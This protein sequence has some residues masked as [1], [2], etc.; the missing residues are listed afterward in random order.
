MNIL[1]NNE[2]EILT[3]SGW[4]PFFGLKKGTSPVKCVVNF[5]D[6]NYIE[7]TPTHKIKTL[8]GE[9]KNAIDLVEG[10]ILSDEKI[11]NNVDF[12]YE[13]FEYV[14]VI[15]VNGEEYISGNLIHHNCAHVKGA[16]EIWTA[17]QATLSTGGKAMLLST[18]NG[19]G[20]FFHKTWVGSQE[21]TNMFHPIKIEWYHHP[22]RDEAWKTEQMKVLQDENRFKQEHCADFISSGNTVIPGFII[23]KY[24]NNHVKEPMLKRGF[25]KNLWVWKEVDYSKQYMVVADCARGDGE[26]YSGCHVIELEGCEQVAEY[27]GKLDTTMYG[28]LLVEIAT[29]YNDALLIVENATSGWA[30][31]QKIIDRNY[32]NLFYMTD[33]VKVVEEGSNYVSK[34]YA[35]DKKKVAGFTTSARTRPLIISKLQ[36]YMKEESIIIHSSRTISELQVFIWHNGKA[37]AMEGYNDD[38]VMSLS[39]GLWVR[40]TA[41]IIQDQNSQLA[42]LALN[43]IHRTSENNYDAVILHPKNLQQDPYKIPGMGE[44]GDFRWLI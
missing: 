11:V 39:I 1:E 6:G 35:Q 26:D 5:Y 12:I 27:K 43:N 29:S 38:L 37:Q 22:D 7:S 3:P 16:E 14:S 10:D 9:F 8:N 18:P 30:V 20:N 41:L 19:M 2:Y 25:D 24:S 36:E 44:D 4:Q 32:K 21:E 34:F 13:E 31:I 17:A 33:D 40:D 28:N 15:G 42:K 23:E